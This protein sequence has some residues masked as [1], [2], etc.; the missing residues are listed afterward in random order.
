[1]R[2]RSP[3]FTLLKPNRFRAEAGGQCA[4]RR[5][6]LDHRCES[7]CTAQQDLRL[8]FLA[9]VSSVSGLR[10]GR[11]TSPQRQSSITRL[12]SGQAG[13][14]SVSR[15]AASNA[16]RPREKAIASSSGSRALNTTTSQPAGLRA[17]SLIK[18][19]RRLLVATAS[20]TAVAAEPARTRWTCPAARSQLSKASGGA[21][22]RPKLAVERPEASAHVQFP[23]VCGASRQSAGGSGRGAG[24][25]TGLG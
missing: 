7:F 16:K 18:G 4:D 19:R 13:R 20:G 17:G 25:G 21:P 8:F 14:Y 3:P 5:I 1:M 11:P 12:N 9:S 22:G 23:V 2:H 15:P 24:L 6:V 10:R